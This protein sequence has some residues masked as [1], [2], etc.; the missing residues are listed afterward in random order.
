MFAPDIKKILNKFKKCWTTIFLL[1]K[2]IV[3][4]GIVAIVNGF[5]FLLKI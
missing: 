3:D 1:S 5:M 2:E 4:R